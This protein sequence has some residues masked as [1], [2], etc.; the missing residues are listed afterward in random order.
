VP[1]GGSYE[2]H[3]Q[4]QALNQGLLGQLGLCGLGGLSGLGGVIGQQQATNQI[5]FG[6]QAGL[7][8][9]IYAHFGPIR[10]REF[11]E[12]LPFWEQLQRSG[13]TSPSPTPPARGGDNAASGSFVY[14]PGKP[15][16][17]YPVFYACRTF[18]D[19]V[20]QSLWPRIV[21]A[22]FFGD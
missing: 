15:Q 13:R 14:V 5:N 16:A 20:R 8:Q 4:Q 2:V 6:D 3:A 17:D 19:W 9:A 7:Q 12:H 18:W 21:S 10:E 11:L 1:T 22:L